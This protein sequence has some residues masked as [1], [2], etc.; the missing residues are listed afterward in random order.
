L[1]H[2]CLNRTSAIDAH[3]PA[4]PL[5]IA[6]LKTVAFLE[7]AYPTAIRAR[8]ESTVVKISII[9]AYGHTA[10]VATFLFALI[11]M[12]IKIIF[13][14]VTF[15]TFAEWAKRRNVQVVHLAFSA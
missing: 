9:A 5:T 12:V 8:V 7:A 6:F 3:L 14:E 13:A 2:H 1:N 10:H 11:D 4:A 15:P